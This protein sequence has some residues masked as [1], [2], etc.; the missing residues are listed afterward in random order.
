MDAIVKEQLL[1]SLTEEARIFVKERKP[2]D[3][4]DAAKIA[5]DYR[6]ARGTKMPFKTTSRSKTE[7]QVG[8]KRCHTCGVMGHLAIDTI[9]PG[10][11]GSQQEQEGSR[12][13]T[14][15]QVRNER[16]PERIK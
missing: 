14:Q 5:E 12:M 8:T 13:K 11:A 10:S 4:M 2:K 16:N 15:T 7:K 1:E 3:S 6:Q 9:L